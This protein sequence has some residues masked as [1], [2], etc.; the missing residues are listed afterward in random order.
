MTHRIVILAAIAPAFAAAVAEVSTNAVASVSPVVTVTNHAGHAVSGELGAV[1][2]GTFEISG[3]RYPLSILPA[4]EQKRVRALAGQDVRT[5]KEKRVAR[6]LEYEL[7]RIKAREEAGDITPSEADA[8][9]AAARASAAYR[10][11]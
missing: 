2:N 6:D 7:A 4:E 9:R 5:A 10:L 11:K 1:T 8:L 3:R